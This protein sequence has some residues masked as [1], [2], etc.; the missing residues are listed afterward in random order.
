M[1]KTKQKNKR[2]CS[3]SNLVHNNYFT[4]DKYDSTNEF[5]RCS[6]G[7]KLN[8]FKE[9][10]NKFE[11]F[12]HNIVEIKPNNKEQIKHLEKGNMCLVQLMNYMISF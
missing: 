9:F 7:S 5:I 6:L 11:L 12:Y 4:F 3:K 8:N 2:S 10:K 1:N